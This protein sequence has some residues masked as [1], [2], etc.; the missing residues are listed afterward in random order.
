MIWNSSNVEGTANQA[1]DMTS[2]H[3]Y[4]VGIAHL[5]ESERNDYFCSTV[6]ISLTPPLFA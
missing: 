5:K 4:V 3:V 1:K 2:L 6:S